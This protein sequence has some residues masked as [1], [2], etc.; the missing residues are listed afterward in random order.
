MSLT[1]IVH[2]CSEV[3]LPLSNGH[4]PGYTVR[5]TKLTTVSSVPPTICNIQNTKRSGY[6]DT[7]IM[8]A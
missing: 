8:N 2:T 1:H 5:D 7:E 3:P 6:S 4:V